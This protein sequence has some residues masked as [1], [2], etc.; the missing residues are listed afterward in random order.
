VARGG[1]IGW[2]SAR[3]TLAV[4]AKLTQLA[5][6]DGEAPF[7]IKNPYVHVSLRHPSNCNRNCWNW[8]IVPEYTP[9]I[10]LS[11]F[12]QESRCLFRSALSGQ[13]V[14]HTLKV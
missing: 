3:S 6:P 14:Q 8:V 5:L 9:K 1:R 12:F 11:V 13:V 4:V 10:H 2:R 7:S